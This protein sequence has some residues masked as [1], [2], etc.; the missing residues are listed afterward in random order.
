MAKRGSQIYVPQTD[1]IYESIAEASAALGVDASNIGKV[2]R[3]ARK[4]AGGYQF[5]RVSPDVSP[6]T[7]QQIKEYTEESFTPKEKKRHAKSRAQTRAKKKAR[8]K[9]RGQAARALQM[10]LKEANRLLSEYEKRGLSGIS[11]IIPEIE[12]IQAMIGR[13]K[14]GGINASFKNLS[15]YNKEELE[16]LKNALDAQLNRK[17]FKNL[18]EQE[19]K[20]GAVAAQL[21]ISGEELEDYSDLL[22]TF[23]N[24]LN[25]YRTVTG[26]GSDPIY[27]AVVH[28]MQNRIA[29]DDLKQLLDDMTAMHERYQEDGYSGNENAF[30]DELQQ[31]LDELYS[32]D[33]PVS[34]EVWEDLFN[35]ADSI[36]PPPGE[37]I[38]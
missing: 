21:G 2:L 37:A 23:W 19:K 32:Y 8:D 15:K 35:D 34:S 10:S 28:A 36:N 17:N 9:Q 38:Y 20:K 27:D 1:T 22:P 30:F 24:L 7:L 14:K 33:N 18:E 3:G 11:S 6:N 13:N 26:K 5:S 25:L 4:A 12:N 31:F 29:H 16:A